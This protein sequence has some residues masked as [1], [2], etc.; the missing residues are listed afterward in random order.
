MNFGFWKQKIYNFYRRFFEFVQVIR[1]FEEN[2][3]YFHL[4]QNIFTNFGEEKF[5][6]SS[7]RRFKFVKFIKQF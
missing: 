1:K 5:E 7:G 6:N 4:K 3:I 2:S